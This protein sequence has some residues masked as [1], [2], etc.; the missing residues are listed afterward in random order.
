MA[1]FPRTVS[2]ES[3]SAL[4][5]PGA[6][7]QKTHTGVQQIRATKAAGWSWTEDFPPLNSGVNTDMALYAFILKAHARGE[8]HEFTHPLTPGSGRAKNGIGTGTV[9]VMG[10]AQVYDTINVDGFG[11]NQTDAVVAGD[12]LK[13]AGDNAV[14]M[15]TANASSDGVGAA[16]IHMPLRIS[17][18]D[19]ASVT[20]TGVTFRATIPGR[21]QFPNSQAP[22]YFA[23]MSITVSEAL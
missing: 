22:V 20:L 7:I 12:V 9:L 14:Y 23:G 21:A 10:A 17:P 18:A 6:L 16:S 4:F 13:I 3:V 2:P 8:I 5:T 11:N 15:A 19:G 1:T